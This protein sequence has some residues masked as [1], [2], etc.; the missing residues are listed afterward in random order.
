MLIDT[1]CHLDD[2][3][4]YPLAES[5]ISD[6]AKDGLYCVVTSSS[7]YASSVCNFAQIGRAHV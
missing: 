4:L 2:E 1:H 5:V 6:M 3:R 7:D